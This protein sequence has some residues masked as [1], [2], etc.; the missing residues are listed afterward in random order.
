MESEVA[1]PSKLN[2]FIQTLL[3]R[4]VWDAARWQAS[5]ASSKTGMEACFACN[6]GELGTA[7]NGCRAG[8][9]ARSARPSAKN[10][11]TPN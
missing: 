5:D 7:E 6:L 8:S 9:N 10:I 3:T 11:F 2:R 1:G 4:H